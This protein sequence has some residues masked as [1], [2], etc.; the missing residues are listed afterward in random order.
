MQRVLFRLGAT[1]VKH[2]CNRT[3]GTVYRASV[4]TMRPQVFCTPSRLFSKT[5]YIQVKE[6]SDPNTLE[7]IANQKITEKAVDFDSAKAARK[8]PLGKMLFQVVGVSAVTIGTESVT[9]T[10]STTENW[11]L[12]KGELASSI[13]EF[14]ES[15]EAAV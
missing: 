1:A 13:S 15:G 3:S 11:G 7:F 4:A 10:K 2:A 14:L 9:V 5:V 6:T 12:L 8:S